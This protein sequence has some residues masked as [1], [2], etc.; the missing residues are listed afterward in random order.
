M[1][2]SRRWVEGKVKSITVNSGLFNSLPSW[3]YPRQAL[4]NAES[5]G[6]C[7]CTADNFSK[8][9]STSVVTTGFRRSE[10][11]FGGTPKRLKTHKMGKRKLVN[12]FIYRG[13][14]ENCIGD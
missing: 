9:C 12:R 11:G 8:S 13:L 7:E 10:V 5:E 1:I 14:G 3:L 4:A 2:Q 6:G